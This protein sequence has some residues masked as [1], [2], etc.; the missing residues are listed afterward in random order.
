[1]PE[2]LYDRLDREYLEYRRRDP[3]MTFA[4]YFTEREARHVKEGG[5]HHSLGQN[6]RGADG[7]I[8]SFWDAGARKANKIMRTAS[9]KPSSRV[10]E[11]GC[12]SLRMGAH[13]I[14]YLDRNCFWG[15]DVVS[16]FYEI[17]EQLIGPG[18]LREKSPRFGVIGELVIA[19]AERFDADLVF[20]SAVCVHVHPD[21]AQGYF[22]DLSRLC[23]KP[24]AKLVFD[25]VLSETTLRYKHTS[26]ARPLDQIIAALPDLNVVK[27]S[28]G[29]EHLKEG[30]KITL[31][32]LEF[33]R[34][35]GG[36]A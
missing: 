18:L 8:V 24:G 16:D 23:R 30:E 32:M 6:L 7:E 34:Q 11:Y 2:T 25:A 14:R 31:A 36:L 3:S 10:I 33:C 35:P 15:L 27:V 9:L 20:S 17:G 1:M 22:G 19:A 13:F 12:G 4:R 28:R 29:N 21:E 5:K 26:W